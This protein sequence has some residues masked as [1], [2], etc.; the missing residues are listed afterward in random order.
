LPPSGGGDDHDDR[1]H[2]VTPAAPVAVVTEPSF[3]G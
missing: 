3:T 1:E 2:K